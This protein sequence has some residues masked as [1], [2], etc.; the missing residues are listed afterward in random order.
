MLCLWHCGSQRKHWAAF[1]ALGCCRL[2]LSQAQP[3]HKSSLPGELEALTLA[4]CFSILALPPAKKEIQA[5]AAMGLGPQELFLFGFDFPE[6]SLSKFISFLPFESFPSQVQDSAM[7]HF[8][9]AGVA[10]LLG[11]RI[12]HFMMVR[13]ASK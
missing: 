4:L 8:V 7:S 5:R 3:N 11:A 6:S 10:T 2:P 13:A 1:H 9:V 12:Q